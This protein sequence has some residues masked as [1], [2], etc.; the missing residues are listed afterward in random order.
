MVVHWSLAEVLFVIVV[1]KS[2]SV[3][4]NRCNVT[5]GTYRPVVGGPFSL[6]F[7]LGTLWRAFKDSPPQ[8]ERPAS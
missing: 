6:F 2:K 4:A 1:P 7:F 3:L 8:T 5:P